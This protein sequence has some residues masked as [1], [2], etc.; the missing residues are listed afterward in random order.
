MTRLYAV[1]KKGKVR[2]F[3]GLVFEQMDSNGEIYV[4]ST[5]TG[6]LGKQL[7]NHKDVVTKGKQ[8]RSVKEQAEFEFAS[9]IKEKTDEGYKSFQQLIQRFQ[10]TEVK[11]FELWSQ[12][13]PQED[14]MTINYL[15]TTLN[16]KYN[17][18]SLWLPLP[19]LAE[20]WKDKK[21]SVKYPR[22]VQPKLN[23]VRCIAVWD[24]GLQQ[25]ILLS[26]G[27]QVYQ[28]PHIA[29]QLKPLL[30][31]FPKV[32]LDGELYLH[33]MPLQ[34]I[35]GIVGLEDIDQFDRKECL[36]YHIYDLAVER[37]NQATRHTVLSAYNI[38]APS[39]H[40]VK[41]VTAIGEIAVKA[42]HDQFV[43][44]GYEGAIVRD[45]EAFYQFGFRDSCLL[46]MKEFLDEEFEIVG[47]SLDENIESFTFKLK[48]NI[49]DQLFDARPTGT[50]K[51]KAEWQRHIDSYI[52][53]KATI[54]FQERTQGGLP[55]QAHVRHKDTPL[56]MEAIRPTE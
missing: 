48:N 41:T 51:D 8:K 54:R 24:E 39:I 4:I 32:Q 44:D 11:D 20:K 34:N 23:G 21:K 31:A 7:I 1:D 49:D 2:V 3:K 26:R 36:E 28:M 30:Q 15:Y 42:W 19:M 35:Y 38:P 37:M 6:L 5:D 13:E 16:I 18:N 40:I 47:C 53:Q 17:T 52:G 12:I 43:A 29:R 33:G 9:K 22:I 55:H 14:V 46:K 27:G 45:P 10:D 25:V 50:L 56:L